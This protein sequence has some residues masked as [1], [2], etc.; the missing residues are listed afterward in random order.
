M[1]RTLV[2]VAVVLVL[3]EAQTIATTFTHSMNIAAQLLLIAAIG[4]PIVFVVRSLRRHVD[5]C[6][7]CG[8]VLTER[9]CS[10]GRVGKRAW[11]E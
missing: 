6:E 7:H 3:L 5:R 2:V 11:K 1:K 9:I 4:V 8:R 10:C